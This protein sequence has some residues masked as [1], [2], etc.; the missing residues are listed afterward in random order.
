MQLCGLLAAAL[1]TFGR[2]SGPVRTLRQESRLSPL[3]F[4][5]TLG[6]LYQRKRAA[7]GALEIAYHRFR[8]LLL[9]RLGLPSTATLQEISRGVRERL[10]WTVPGF[11]E[12]LQ[13]CER[14]VKS[15]ELTDAQSM[16]LIQ[17]LHD[18]SR[19]FGLAKSE[20]RNQKLE[21]RNRGGWV[22]PGFCF[23][24]SDCFCFLLV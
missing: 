20:I 13:R 1:L 14:G 17:E 11:W 5:E 23:R 3:E 12:T 8:F 15:Q 10:G 22:F 18:Y 9:R 21:I 16:Q 19:R 4:V 24:I 6:D 7:A 2:H